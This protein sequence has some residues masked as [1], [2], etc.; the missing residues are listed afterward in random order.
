[1]PFANKGAQIAQLCLGERP[2][3]SI[4]CSRHSTPQFDCS[5]CAILQMR[6]DEEE[7][8]LVVQQQEEARF[9]LQQK[10]L[11]ELHVAE[12]KR[13]EEQRRQVQIQ[14]TV[15]AARTDYEIVLNHWNA[16][17][18]V[19]LALELVEAEKKYKAVSG[20]GQA[21]GAVLPTASR[22][23]DSLGKFDTVQKCGKCR[24]TMAQQDIDEIRRVIAEVDKKESEIAAFS[25]AI[26]HP[27]VRES[28]ITLQLA[29][30]IRSRNAWLEVTRPAFETWTSNITVAHS[31]HVK[32]VE[33]TRIQQAEVQRQNQEIAKRLRA[34]KNSRLLLR[35][36]FLSLGLPIFIYVYFFWARDWSDKCPESPGPCPGE[37]WFVNWINSNSTVGWVFFFLLLFAAVVG[38]LSVY[39]FIKLLKDRQFD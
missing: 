39:A 21:P 13:I 19:S 17:P 34:R 14:R 24:I 25:E 29:A 35:S 37:S 26:K 10:A 8:F 36:G 1:M 30:E 11:K 18:S 33:E 28:N 32:H 16:S 7:R 5:D 22:L 20:S 9:E 15:Q 4:P 27:L 38:G 6:A 31:V 3:M 2:D 23:I 12:N